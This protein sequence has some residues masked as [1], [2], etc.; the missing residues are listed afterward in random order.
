MR[1]PLASSLF[2][3]PDLSWI[4]SN[5]LS[6]CLVSFSF[7]NRATRSLPFNFLR[8]HI[9]STIFFLLW[10]LDHYAFVVTFLFAWWI[11]IRRVLNLLSRGWISV[12]HF[13]NCGVEIKIWEFESKL[14]F[15]LSI[16]ILYSE[17]K[18]TRCVCA[19]IFSPL[20]LDVKL[21]F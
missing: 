4:T 11:M 18:S 17:T 1:F 10:I 14:F 12:F 16:Y 13:S 15:S 2:L 3:E 8:V 20:G 6:L 19:K 21:D 5:S 7:Q 9:F